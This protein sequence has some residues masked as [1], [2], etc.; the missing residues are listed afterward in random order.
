MA[1]SPST[2]YTTPSNSFQSFD[3]NRV[4]DAAHSEIM[5]INQGTNY[6]EEIILNFSTPV[7]VRL[8]QVRVITDANGAYAL[9]VFETEGTDVQ[10]NDTQTCGLTAVQIRKM[11]NIFFS[12]S[13]TMIRAPYPNWL[14]GPNGYKPVTFV[15]EVYPGNT[16]DMYSNTDYALADAFSDLPG[17]CVVNLA[18][19]VDPLQQIPLI[20]YD[21]LFAANYNEEYVVTVGLV[22]DFYVASI[23][24]YPQ[25]DL[26]NEVTAQMETY[27]TAVRALRDVEHAPVDVAY[28]IRTPAWALYNRCCEP[29]HAGLPRSKEE[30]DFE[31]MVWRARIMGIVHS[32]DDDEEDNA[33]VHSMVG[34]IIA[35]A[36]SG[37]GNAAGDA[38]ASKREQKY[39][40]ERMRLAHQ[41]AMAQGLQ[42]SE[43]GLKNG[44][45]MTKA[46][47]YAQYQLD[48]ARLGLDA[49]T[50]HNTVNS[51][52]YS[53][54]SVRNLRPVSYRT[55]DQGG[56]VRSQ[57][58]SVPTEARR[59][60]NA[61]VISGIS[62]R[63][64]SDV[65]TVHVAH[66]DNV[67]WGG[68]PADAGWADDMEGVEL[69]PREPAAVGAAAARP[70]A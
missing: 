68:P 31:S 67:Q 13:T 57:R 70:T 42:F 30:A 45:I 60:S 2:S 34:S 6:D 36:A 15:T 24:A 69:P 27:A 7:L 54:G 38:I 16:T 47:A 56:A 10:L 33:T 5:Y 12:A 43:L 58:L 63:R 59:E 46:K 22:D 3:N 23:S 18:N 20:Y 50:V 11:L 25:L 40:L 14:P 48:A 1:G 55:P 52:N 37:M 21:G 61:S 39:A 62:S 26:A 28:A 65:S 41:N 32:G 53:S 64:D 66:N 51:H 35:G 4:S 19:P 49:A 17:R 29:E 8:R 9:C 44:L